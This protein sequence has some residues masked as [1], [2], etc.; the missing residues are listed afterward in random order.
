MF[1]CI[2]ASGVYCNGAAKESV[3]HSNESILRNRISRR[4]SLGLGAGLGLSAI[5]AACS[6][7]S[8]AV[9]PSNLSSELQ[10]LA[11]AAQKEGTVTYYTSNDQSVVDQLVQAMD[12]FEIDMQVQ[13]LNSGP[14]AQR[15]T[16]EAQAGKFVG[17]VVAIGDP[18][19]AASALKEGWFAPIGDVP[20]VDSW[21]EQFTNDGYAIISINPYG[22]GFNTEKVTTKPD[23][24]EFALDSKWANQVMMTDIRTGGPVGTA[25]W[26]VL[27][28]QYGDDFLESFAAL[29]PRLYD[30]ATP[31]AQQLSAGAGSLF[32]LC[33]AVTTAQ[34]IDQGAPLGNLIPDEVPTTGIETAACISAKTDHP[35]AA[36]F[37]LAFLLSDQGQKILN[38]ASSSPNNAPETAALPKSF[39]RP[40]YD[41]ATD[42]AKKQKIVK[43]LG[44]DK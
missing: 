10:S 38:S 30:S 27:Q 2:G 40:D 21:P 16:A 25:A 18:L 26:Q 1:K 41:A 4:A 39:V 35:N 13:R 5:L 37:L 31:A 3:M 28:N 32:M 17:D 23:D 34:L 9:D 15:Y 24:W 14:L 44:L 36:K 42:D 22:L 7:P 33:S 6:R 20:G 29:K 11:E 43:L 12:S 8:A 19:F